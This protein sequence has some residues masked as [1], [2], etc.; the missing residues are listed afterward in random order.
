MGAS[1]IHISQPC[2]H[3][4]QPHRSVQEPS[5]IF[6]NIKE[7]SCDIFSSFKQRLFFNNKI[8]IK[9]TF[10]VA[11]FIN[12]KKWWFY[13]QAFFVFKTCFILPLLMFDLNTSRSTQTQKLNNNNNRIV[14]T[15]SFAY[16]LQ[17]GSCLIHDWREKKLI[18]FAWARA[19]VTKKIKR[20]TILFAS[21][22][23]N[24]D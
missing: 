3:A 23:Q 9:R 22:L 8:I 14:D 2:I 10:F 11:P 7:L 15:I 24:K 6:K 12:V 21:R 19:I 18:C 20:F 16:I 17:T 1:S 13:K 5:P 4:K